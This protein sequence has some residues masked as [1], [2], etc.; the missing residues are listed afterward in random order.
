VITF[1]ILKG[2]NSTP[3]TTVVFDLCTAGTT[4][5]MTGF[6]GSPSFLVAY[7]DGTDTSVDL[8]TKVRRLPSGQYLDP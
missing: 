5:V 2:V 6:T 8:T 3:T 7:A 1:A 4:T